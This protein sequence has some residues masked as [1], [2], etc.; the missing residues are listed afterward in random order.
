M[1][2]MRHALI[3]DLRQTEEGREVLDKWKR[4]TNPRTE[5]DLSSIRKMSGYQQKK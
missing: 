3:S 5:A 2:Y 1:G 4:Y